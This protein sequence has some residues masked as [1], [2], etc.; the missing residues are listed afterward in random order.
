MRLHTPT[1]SLTALT[2]VAAML[3]FASAASA[4]PAHGRHPSPLTVLA[5]GLNGPGGLS[6]AGKDIYVA[7]TDAGEV[8]RID[9]RNGVKKVVVK[10]LLGP[11][12]VAENGGQL[13]IV[14]GGSEVPDASLTGDSS[15]FL[16]YPGQRPR[17]VADLEAYELGHNPDGQLQ[18]DPTTHQPLD[19]LSNPF[20]VL[21]QR[22]TGSYFVADAGA[23]DVLLVS[24]NGH[25]R[26]FFVPPLVTTGGCAGAPNNDPQHV[27]CDPVPT[28]I[29]Y[30]PHNTLYVSTLSALAPGQGRVYVLDADTGRVLRVIGGLDAPTGVAVAPNGTVYVSEVTYGAPEGDGPPPQG[31]DPSTIG[32]IVRI[33]RHG[34]RS[35]AQVTMPL[36]LAFHGNTLYTT[37]WSIAG[38]LGMTDAGEVVA[39]RPWAFR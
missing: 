33:G 17:L 35:Y 36:G 37:A 28:G 29:A 10:G 26:P 32:R 20:A 9:M 24:P 21:A 1:R 30:G 5:S 22:H 8:T 39:V 31:F 3:S 38:Q 4:A 18:F 14:T 2:L 13:A 19:A 16:A 25:I 6:L 15:L 11:A 7:E 27:G 34:D 12:A 23:N